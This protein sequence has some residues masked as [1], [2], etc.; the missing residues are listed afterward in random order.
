MGKKPRKFGGRVRSD[1]SGLAASDAISRTTAESVQRQLRKMSKRFGRLL[2]E[3]SHLQKEPISLWLDGTAEAIR[4]MYRPIYEWHPVME[5]NRFGSSVGGLPYVTEE[6]PWPEIGGRH[7]R[8]PMNP[9]VQLNLGEIS[10]QTGVDVGSGLLQVWRHS[11]GDQRYPDTWLRVIEAADVR[12]D[13][14]LELYPKTYLDRIAYQWNQ[15][16]ISQRVLHEFFEDEEDDV[17]D[18]VNGLAIK[19]LIWGQDVDQLR[20]LDPWWVGGEGVGFGPWQI[21]GWKPHG[22]T[23][24]AAE[25]G[26]IVIDEFVEC[27]DGDEDEDAIL[28]AVNDELTVLEKILAPLEK[29][30][31]RIEDRKIGCQDNLFG[32][33]SYLDVESKPQSWEMVTEGWQPLFNVTGPFEDGWF[34]DICTVYFRKQ[35]GQFEYALTG[36]FQRRM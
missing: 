31:M 30:R 2:R 8:E 24:P 32:L 3:N 27:A 1:L 35:D 20:Q 34:V 11:P 18:Y 22:F 17:L 16:V 21:T 29:A 7:A 33:P 10:E 14:E 5:I 12:S 9:L 36:E 26:H 6:H 13:A 28:A 4:P 23:L 19:G 15:K 25:S